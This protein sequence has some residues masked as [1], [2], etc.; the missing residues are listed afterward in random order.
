MAAALRERG[1]SARVGYQVGRYVVDVV[2]GEGEG[3]VAIDC[4][5]SRHGNEAHVDRAM[6]LRRAGWRTADAYES[7]WAEEPGRFALELTLTYPDLE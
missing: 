6:L 2:A 7:R 3:A 4:V 1:I 5:P